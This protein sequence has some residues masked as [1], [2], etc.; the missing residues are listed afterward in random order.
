MHAPF[1]QAAVIASLLEMPA[2]RR[3]RAQVQAVEHGFLPVRM[4]ALTDS[5]LHGASVEQ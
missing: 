3:A 2:D 5:V 1:V 4:P